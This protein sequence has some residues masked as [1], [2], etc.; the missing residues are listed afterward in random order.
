MRWRDAKLIV[1]GVASLWGALAGPSPADAAAFALTEDP[2]A[3]YPDVAVDPA[4]TAHVVW[5]VHRSG[6]DQLAYCRVPRGGRACAPLVA[7]DLPGEGSDPDVVVMGSG[8]VVLETNVIADFGG[9]VGDRSYVFVSDD[10]GATFSPPSVLSQRFY[11]VGDEVAAGP[12]DF[13]LSL[14]GGFG[15]A[16]HGLRYQAAPLNA[17]TTEIADLTGGEWRKAYHPSVAFPDPLRPLVAYGD[18]DT[19]SFRLFAGGTAYN[20]AASWGPEVALGRGDEPRLAG[21]PRGVFLL[22][23]D[24]AVPRQYRVRRYDGTTFVDPTVVSDPRLGSAIFRDFVQDGGGR[25][26]AVFKQRPRRNGPWSLRHRTSTDGRRWN[27]VETLVSE[28]PS[29]ALFNLRVAAAPDGSGGVVAD[30]NGKGPI[31]FVPFAA[32][33]GGD[34]ADCV[35]T[36]T[37]GQTLAF[38]RQGCFTR[39]GD[40]FTATGDVRVNGI[41]LLSDATV[42]VDRGDRTLTTDAPVEVRIGHIVL[43]AQRIAWRLPPGTGEIRDLAGNP[44]TFNSAEEGGDIFGLPVSGYT[45]PRVVGVGRGAVDVNVG[46]PAPFD[47]PLGGGASAATTLHANNDQGLE[48]TDVT[49]AVQGASFGIAGL[50]ALELEFVEGTSTLRGTGHLLLP[51]V[52]SP[53]EIT[54]QLTDGEFDYGRGQFGPVVPG[55]PVATNVFLRQI[56]FEV[57]KGKGCAQPTQIVGGALFV[58]GQPEVAGRPLIS[59]DGDVSYSFPR[60]TC[61]LPGVLAV[62]GDGALAGFDVATAGARL[63][64][65]PTLSFD[66]SA[67]FDVT[68]ASASV[69]VQGGV[70]L[71]K[72]RFFASGEASAEIAGQSIASFDVIVSSV[73]M[74]G[75]GTAL[76]V[77]SPGSLIEGDPEPIE[78]GFEYPWGGSFDPDWPDTCDVN[79]GAYKPTAFSSARRRAGATG[80]ASFALPRGLPA[81]ELRLAGAGAAPGALLTGPGGLRVEY[82]AGATDRMQRSG[83]QIVSLPHLGRTHIRLVRPRAGRY[84]VDDVPG[85]PTITSVEVA[86]GLPQ[87]S[88][89]GRVRRTSGGRRLLTFRVRRIAGQRL[90]FFE[91]GGGVT[92]ALGATA[93][94]RGRL[95][96]R[97]ATGPGGRRTVVALVEQNGTP[98][99]R[100]TVARYRVSAS[101]PGRVSGLRVRRRGQSLLITWRGARGAQR[102]A[103]AWRL[104]DGRR[105]ARITRRHRLVLRDVPGIDAGTIRV[106]GLRRDNVAGRVAKATVKAKP[107]KRPRRR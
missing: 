101:R 63:T 21:G 43:G 60:S 53:L 37:V 73:G 30:A 104:S 9:Y 103:V 10:G 17:T 16:N 12:G 79:L 15:G 2:A 75:C 46:L 40:R 52:S 18:L 44:A 69:E 1:I 99:A 36:V 25:L 90:R 86:R 66:A 88:V 41:D 50:G 96:F 107:K 5:D 34:G 7:L 56:T 3:R 19:V 4:G 106:A 70:D 85:A 54:I 49:F 65:D 22:D 61:G 91:Q 31:T 93:R 48:V 95:R 8:R 38:A 72:K 6:N 98:R 64:T 39:Q 20:D 23:S 74:A 97:P 11:G 33:G 24:D 76:S 59:V 28:S 42:V 27:R 77:P 62:R 51:V 14:V 32:R 55:I 82:P 57:V 87:P 68:A 45:V 83:V 81:A 26:H 80:R 84:T 71:A 105:E 35:P 89:R 100:V 102:Y 94:A 58:T 13:A 92:K 67:G 78:A 47:G 29:V